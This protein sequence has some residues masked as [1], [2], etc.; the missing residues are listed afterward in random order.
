[1]FVTAFYGI[2]EP[3]ERTLTYVNGGHNPP[4]HFSPG[5]GLM[6]GLDPTGMALGVLDDAEFTEASVPLAPGDVVV[7]YT[8]G[9]TEA[10]NTSNEL[11]GEERLR[12]FIV[13]NPGLPAAV[14]VQAIFDDVVR[15]SEGEP[16]ADDITLLVVRVL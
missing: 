4:I 7:L 5:S 6:T 11:Y 14:L 2:V 8:D 13:A 9:V 12:A 3:G 10:L 15:F 16:Q 1:M